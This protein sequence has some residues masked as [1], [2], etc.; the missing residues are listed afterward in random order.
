MVKRLIPAVLACVLCLAP[1]MAGQM[2]AEQ[3]Q[4]IEKALAASDQ[5]AESKK[6]IVEQAGFTVGEYDAFAAP[7]AEQGEKHAAAADEHPRGRMGT[8]NEGLVVMVIGM[9]GTFLF[10]TI[11]VICM[12]GMHRFLVFFGRY[13][14][15]KTEHHAAAPAPA[16]VRIE[17][18]AL[19][20][21]V[22]SAR[23]KQ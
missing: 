10:L 23:M 3:H 14:P 6:T 4:E 1:L 7:K 20:I 13:F 21:A 18:I 9:S 16:E 5:S 15:E 12:Y 22:A 8:M 11:M 2:T 17:E 19:A